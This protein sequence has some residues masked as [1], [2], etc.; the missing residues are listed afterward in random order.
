[1]EEIW[2]AGRTSAD[3]RAY[4]QRLAEAGELGDREPTMADPL[5]A[6]SGSGAADYLG[7]IT[8]ERHLGAMQGIGQGAGCEEIGIGP[9]VGTR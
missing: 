4:Y 8:I 7:S 6:A 2:T 9:H 5:V 3:A 1:M